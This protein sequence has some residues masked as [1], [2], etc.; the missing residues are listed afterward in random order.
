MDATTDCFLKYMH[1][2]LH[3]LRKT[4]TQGFLPCTGILLATYETFQPLLRIML[5]NS[6]KKM[7]KIMK[8]TDYIEI[9]IK[10]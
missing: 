5:L 6:L 7:H 8:E 10:I 2:C 1:M 4:L 9:V 3:L